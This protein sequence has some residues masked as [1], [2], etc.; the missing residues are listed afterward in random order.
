MDKEENKL[1]LGE[2]DESNEKIWDTVRRDFDF[3]G[4][5]A[6]FSI[7]SCKSKDDKEGTVSRFY[8]SRMPKLQ[9]KS[10]NIPARN[11]DVE[12][13]SMEED[14]Q[15]LLHFLFQKSRL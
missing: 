8:S 6:E 3:V 11:I 1:P 4:L 5:G 2:K 14:N 10:K 12:I 15:S 9:I 13:S 7:T